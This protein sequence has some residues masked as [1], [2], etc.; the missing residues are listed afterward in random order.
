MRPSYTAGWDGRRL[1]GGT[2]DSHQLPGQG[3][4]LSVISNLLLFNLSFVFLAGMRFVTACSLWTPL[5]L[6]L[7]L[8]SPTPRESRHECHAIT[9]RPAHQLPL[10]RLLSGAA[11]GLLSL[12]AT[13][14]RCREGPPGFAFKIYFFTN[15]PTCI[16]P[17]L[18]YWGT[19]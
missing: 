17:L 7:S 18:S 19:L 15:F 6:G 11:C 14:S 2:G 13:R 10:R 3:Q 5:L 9:L 4:L 12:R 1:T 16:I 8:W